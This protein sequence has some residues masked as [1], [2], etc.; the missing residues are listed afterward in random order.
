MTQTDPFL[1]AWGLGTG[2]NAQKCFLNP[3]QV[4]T[5]PQGAR[6]NVELPTGTG[7]IKRR[8]LLQSNW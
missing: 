6:Y 4:L 5:T 3:G 7:S 1:D 2:E 8:W